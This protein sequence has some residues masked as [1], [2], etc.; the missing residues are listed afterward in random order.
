[1][2]QDKRSDL[3]VERQKRLLARF[4]AEL[5]EEHGDLY[6][7]PT[8]EIARLIASHIAES[9]E[10]TDEDR[11]ALDGLKARDIEVLLSLH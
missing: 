7:Q 10:L 4:V 5:C 3:T 9:A 2:L 6:Y 8:S 1:M 11:A